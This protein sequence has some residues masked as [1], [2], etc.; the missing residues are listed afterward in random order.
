MSCDVLLLRTVEQ[1]LP[2]NTLSFGASFLVLSS[3]IEAR[4]IQKPELS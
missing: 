1:K 2:V 3:S 4:R